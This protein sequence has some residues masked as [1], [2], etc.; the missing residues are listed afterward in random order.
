MVGRDRTG[1]LVVG[2]RGVIVLRCCLAV[3]IVSCLRIDLRWTA[4]IDL[5]MSALRKLVALWI[6]LTGG[7]ASRRV[8][9]TLPVNLS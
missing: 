3:A 7:G 8:W 2:T 5:V 9:W 6:W 4:L 1:L